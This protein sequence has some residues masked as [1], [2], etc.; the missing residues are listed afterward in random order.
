MSA[1]SHWKRLA[2]RLES[3]LAAL[4]NEKRSRHV[5]EVFWRVRYHSDG[6]WGHADTLAEAR[7]VKLAT[8]RVYRVTVYRVK[9]KGAAP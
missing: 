4:K 2:K 7:R 5:V 3:E 1:E 8:G 6:S 9:R